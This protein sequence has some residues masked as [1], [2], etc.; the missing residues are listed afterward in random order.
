MGGGDYMGMH[1]HKSRRG[2]WAHED[3]ASMP[4]GHGHGGARY[5]GP[6]DEI[7]QTNIDAGEAVVVQA[8]PN[9]PTL[10]LTVQC[11]DDEDVSDLSYMLFGPYDDAKN[12]GEAVTQHEFTL[13][14]VN[15]SEE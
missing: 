12:F 5:V 9:R 2:V 3:H 6:V 4:N 1:E 13:T 11:R 15:S 8:A 14:R 10:I 7:Q